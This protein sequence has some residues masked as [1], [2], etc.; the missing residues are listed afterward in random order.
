MVWE[1]ETPPFS[2][3]PGQREQRRSMS[4]LVLSS[5]KGH[6][7]SIAFHLCMLFKGFP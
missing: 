7:V 4:S 2:L 3:G 1:S 5:V 6:F